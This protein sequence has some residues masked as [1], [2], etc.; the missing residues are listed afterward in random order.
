MEQLFKEC[1]DFIDEEY[2]RLGHTLGYRFLTCSNTL[3]N[4]DM[5]LLY[6]SQS[7]AGSTDIKEHPKTSCEYGSPFF[8]ERWDGKEAGTSVLQQQTRQMFAMLQAQLKIP[9]TVRNF[10][11]QHILSGY[12][13]PF[14]DYV[15]HK[16]KKETEEEKK[17]SKE[18]EKACLASAH[19]LWQK[20][21]QKWTPRYIL[22]SGTSVGKEVKNILKS[23]NFTIIEGTPIDIKW[24]GRKIYIYTAKRDDKT[25]RIASFPSLSRYQTMNSRKYTIYFREMLEQIFSS[26]QTN[27]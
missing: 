1:C 25:I 9:G 11:E 7:P 12:F 3:L 16:N 15:Y 22:I 6:L 17:K 10:A 2:Q 26:K 8:V 23:L 20:I 27:D 14:R 21:F 5:K 24:Q 18:K 19:Q 13:I 4:P